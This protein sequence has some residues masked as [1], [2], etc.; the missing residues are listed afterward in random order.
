MSSLASAL[1]GQQ[2][3]VS[4]GGAGQIPLSSLLQLMGK[5]GENMS[6]LW[7]GF[8]NWMHGYQWDGMAGNSMLNDLSS[9]AA[10]NIAGGAAGL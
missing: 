1:M 3:P 8:D 5:N 7:N 10:G 4:G 6:G 9:Q 2:A